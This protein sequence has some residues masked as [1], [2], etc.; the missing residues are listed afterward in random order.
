MIKI[1]QIS[2]IHLSDRIR[3]NLESFNQTINR[4]FNRLTKSHLLNRNQSKRIN[5][6]QK[7]LKLIKM[8]RKL[9]NFRMNVLLVA[10]KIR[11][12]TWQAIK[13]QKWILIVPYPIKQFIKNLKL[14]LLK[15][16]CQILNKNINNYV[17]NS[18]ILK[19]NS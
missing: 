1:Y 14:I 8:A 13:M 7:Q 12:K 5:H 17:N 11:L 9:L 3:Q 16:F 4:S 15:K 18:C 10:F 6:L 19:N 2:P